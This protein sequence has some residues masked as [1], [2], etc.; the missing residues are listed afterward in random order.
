MN[1][2]EIEYILA[3]EQEKNLTKAAKRSGIS[4]P[5]ISKCIRNIETELGVSLFEKI[6]GEYIPTE[7]GELF[8]SFAKA[9]RERKIQFL[10]ELQDLVQF[11]C[12]TVRVGI[13]P[14]R[15]SGLT[16]EVLPE[17]RKNFPDL[18]L[19]LHEEDVDRLEEMLQKGL[20]D[21]VYFVVDE[22]YRE[23]HSE[24][25]IELLGKEEI[26]LTV[27]KGTP[28]RKAPVIKYGFDYPWVDITQ[29]QSKPFITL[30]KDMRIG[31]ICDRVL[32]EYHMSPEIIRFAD[33]RTAHKLVKKGYG[34][35]ICGSLGMQNHRDQFDIYSFGDR[36]I[37]WE[38]VAAYR[39]G[40]YRT[41]PLQ[42]LTQLYQRAAEEKKI[43][44]NK[45]V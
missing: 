19:E 15:S 20:L 33:M 11:K 6:S 23:K 42:Y 5:A 22:D 12:G 31:K 30:N 28:L 13:T 10:N 17:F 27:K 16:P 7:A 37:V 24:F 18:H 34:S 25:Y 39:V 1:F 41:E 8:L 2:K 14:A 32:E 21:V 45:N 4:Q 26:V 29:F 9:M 38:F 40:S 44:N 3:V 43:V 36:K 35:C